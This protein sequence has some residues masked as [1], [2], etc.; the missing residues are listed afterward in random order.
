MD[1]LIELANRLKNIR[2]NDI[3]D[4]SIMETK[5]SLLGEVKSQLLFGEASDGSALGYYKSP[6]YAEF[7][8]RYV[9]SYHAP[10]GVYNFDLYGDFQNAMYVRPLLTEI[11]IGSKD[12]KEGKL[13]KL[14][15]GA[16]NVWGLNSDSEYPQNT[17]KPVFIRRLRTA[18]NI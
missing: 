18:L 10:F 4:D 15:G 11:E 6:E 3:F 8:S 2:L 14:A 7:K 5:E 16:N 17:F 9:A 12:W 1:K 13:E